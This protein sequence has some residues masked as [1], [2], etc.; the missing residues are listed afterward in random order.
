MVVWR[1]SLLPYSALQAAIQKMHRSGN[2]TS[3]KRT[4]VPS[5][6]LQHGTCVRCV[7]GAR[8]GT[9]EPYQGTRFTLESLGPVRSKE[10]RDALIGVERSRSAGTQ[11]LHIEEPGFGNQSIPMCLSA[12]AYPF[13]LYSH[14]Q[15][16]SR[17]GVVGPL[18]TSVD[19][20]SAELNCVT[21]IGLGMRWLVGHAV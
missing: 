13:A 2:V 9:Q 5:Y 6:D 8:I 7:V 11:R 18:L 1:Q 21:E 15:I 19:A 12:L 10:A 17:R 20:I 3:Y 16:A 4:P 14:G